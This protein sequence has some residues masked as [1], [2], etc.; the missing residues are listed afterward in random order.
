MKNRPRLAVFLLLILLLLIV[1]FPLLGYFFEKKGKFIEAYRLLPWR[2]ELLQEQ[3]L[4]V[5]GHAPLEAIILFQQ[6]RLN[7]ALDVT[8]QLALAQAYHQTGQPDLAL[9]EWESLF[10]QKKYTSAM[11]LLMAQI[12][13]QRANYPRELEICQIGAQVFP[14][15][16]EFYWR[17]GLLKLADNPL[18]A[19]GFFEQTQKL[20]PQPV[21]RFPE[22]FL[23]LQRAALSEDLAYQ[24]S[25]SAQ[26]LASFNEWTLAQQA[27]EKAVAI[28]PAYGPAWALLGEVR[29]QTGK[30]DAYIALKNALI[31]APD[32]LLT[33]A[34]FGL[35]WQRR[36]DF[37]KAL[38]QFEQAARLD[39]LNPLWLMTIAELSFRQGAV[40]QS[41]QYYLRAVELAP[42]DAAPWRALALY[43]VQ[44]E[45]C[46]KETGLN[47]ALKAN[48]LAPEDWRNPDALGQALMGLGQNESARRMFILSSQLAP[49][50]PGPHF[51]YGLLLLRM[52]ETDLAYQS[53][54]KA[55]TLASSGPLAE[56]IQNTLSRYFP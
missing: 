24:L 55:K 41:Y 46:L 34:Y 26:T 2:H 20:D 29:Q 16:A 13:H 9:Q 42:E 43:C 10:G 25:I 3:G 19:L 36:N 48:T 23:T 6:A 56:S 45:F 47:A 22:L 53:L 52:Q 5:A 18:L 50:E 39:A 1:L 37:Q 28:S 27:L 4:L 54:Q 51:H 49:E 12:Y 44:T 17:M 30:G 11:L 21:Y 31:F 38:L 40:E 8:G 7:H 35:Y 14:D 33:R 15:I 32:L